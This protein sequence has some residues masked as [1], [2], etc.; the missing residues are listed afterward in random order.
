MASRSNSSHKE[1]SDGDSS[2]DKDSD[3]EEMGLFVRR[4]N[5]FIRN[6]GIKHSDKNLMK[7]RRQSKGSR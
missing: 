6:N 7:F 2:S 4:Y 5:K 3:D 1:Q